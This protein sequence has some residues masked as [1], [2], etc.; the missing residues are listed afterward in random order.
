[1]NKISKVLIGLSVLALSLTSQVN[2]FA[3][4]PATVNLGSAGNFTILA[5]S[6]ISTTGATAIGGNIGASPVAAS[7]ITGFGLIMDST[8]T[9][10]TSSLVSGRVYAADY[11]SPTPATMSTAIS[12]MQTAYVDA[13]GRTTPTATELGA[14]N[15]GGMTLAPGLY[16][17]S[18][19]VI[20]P[21]SATDS[22]PYRQRPETAGHIP[23]RGLDFS[24][25]GLRQSNIKF[26][27]FHRTRP[28]LRFKFIFCVKHSGLIIDALLYA[29]PE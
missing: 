1:M 5:K 17:F 28:N 7:S 20:I 11:A 10:A 24:R 3:A 19:N 16:K 2:V 12:D 4:G 14:G 29:Y 6:G 23:E 18:S 13:A 9:F 8:N 26:P 27:G 15:L 25:G 21:T 22:C